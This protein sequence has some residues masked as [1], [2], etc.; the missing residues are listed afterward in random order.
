LA[1]HILNI[2][3][4]ECTLT[5]SRGQII[6][7]DS[8]GRNKTSVPL[9]DV[10]S[11]VVTSF[12]ATVSSSLLTAAAKHGVAIVFCEGFRPISILLPAN[13]STDTL[14][15]RAHVRIKSRARASLW[16]RTV[17]AKVRNQTLLAAALA[18]GHL[19]LGKMR[20]LLASRSDYKESI[21]ARLYWDIY[22]DSIG[23]PSFI[24]DQSLG[25]I[26]ALL[27]YGY[28]VLLSILLQKL[29]AVGL[30]PTF[31]IFHATREHAT[32]LAYDL[33]EPFRPC[34]DY[35]VA[36]WA[37]LATDREIPLDVSTPFRQWVTE[38]AISPVRYL[39]RS[40]E[41]RSAVEEVVRSFRRAVMEQKPSLYLPWTP[42]ASKWDGS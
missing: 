30:D 35:R 12:Q 22:G 9:E 38:F 3:R 5:C 16:R 28:A 2:D 36:Q 20:A 29:F 14:L 13:R 27:N 6:C 1:Y 34:V 7:V 26:N 42:K 18:P 40:M 41:V 10:A 11:I 39:N 17:N 32:P 25:G 37:I 8:D 21:A 33:M 4:A 24:R 23:H 15:T 19:G 31:G